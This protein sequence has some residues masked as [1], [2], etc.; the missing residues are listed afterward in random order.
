V[1]VTGKA[2]RTSARPGDRLHVLAGGS[3]AVRRYRAP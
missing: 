1:V 2:K 3:L